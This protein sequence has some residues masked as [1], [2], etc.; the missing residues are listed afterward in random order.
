MTLEEVAH[1]YIAVANENM[2][3]PMREISIARGH[4]IK[5]HVLA[6]FGGAGGQHACALARALGI[7]KI[8]IHRFAGIL[9]AY[10]LGL[11][12]VVVEKQEP[13]SGILAETSLPGLITRLD[14]LTERANT[15]LRRQGNFQQVEIRRYLNLRYQGTDTAMMVLESPGTIFK[16]EFIKT[17][18]RE[19]G[20]EISGRDIRVDDIRVRVTGRSE[21]VEE[22]QGC[23]KIGS[24]RAG[25]PNAMLFFRGMEKHP[26]IFTKNPGDRRKNSR[27]RYYDRPNLDFAGGTRL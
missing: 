5:E 24:D 2:A 18:K 10:G 27:S 1:G 9:S 11:A 8:H 15:E 14:D 21:G 4:D 3:R 20:F 26:G 25:F 17:H 22:N 16:S 7:R 6:C 19:F 12:D 13:A 23:G